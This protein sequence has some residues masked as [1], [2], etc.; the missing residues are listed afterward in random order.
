VVVTFSYNHSKHFSAN[1][2]PPPPPPPLTS[3]FQTLHPVFHFV[4]VAFLKKTH[5]FLWGMS[6]V[7]GRFVA[8]FRL[9]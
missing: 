7:M 1:T 5:N 3:P 6:Q 2:P 8:S 9:G 4:K